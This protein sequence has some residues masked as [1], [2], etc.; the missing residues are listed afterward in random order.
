[1]TSIEANISLAQA[2]L[3]AW[4]RFVSDPSYRNL[5]RW[6]MTFSL[7][8]SLRIHM[9]TCRNGKNYGRA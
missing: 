7:L 6:R 3:Q 5:M 9:Q 2:E 1:M 4:Q 8:V